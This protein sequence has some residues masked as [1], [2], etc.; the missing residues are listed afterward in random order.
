MAFVPQVPNVVMLTMYD[1]VVEI[2]AVDEV[3]KS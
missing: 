3:V 1:M 2:P